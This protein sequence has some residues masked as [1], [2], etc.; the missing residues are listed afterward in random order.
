MFIMTSIYRDG[1]HIGFSKVT[2]DLTERKAVESKLI[3]A[4]EKSAVLKSMVLANI[5]HEI[6]TPMHGMLSA[7]TLLMDS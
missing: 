3:V 1:V 6:R 5:S 2:R 4:Y 7:L